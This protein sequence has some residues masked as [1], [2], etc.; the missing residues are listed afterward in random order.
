MTYL[1]KFV[2]TKSLD[3]KQCL[4]GLS[5]RI[6]PYYPSKHLRKILGMGKSHIQQP[7]FTHFPHQEKPINKF[8]SLVILIILPFKLTI[9]V[10]YIIFVSP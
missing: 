6:I 9:A 3:T 10:A 8:T 4:A 7:K 1:K 5:L 2:G